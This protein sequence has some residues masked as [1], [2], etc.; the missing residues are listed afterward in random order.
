MFYINKITSDSTV[1]FAAEELKKYLR[2][3]IPEGGDV[4]ISYNPAAK[5]GFRLGLMQEFG[6]SVSDVEEAEL[7]DIIYIDCDEEG[8][9]IAGDNPR[10]V[11]LAVYEYLRQNGC[12][13]LF[14]GVDGEYIPMKDISPIKYR[15]A[16]S[17]RYRGMCN[18][19]AEYQS[20]MLEFIDF[21][22]KV[23]MN[24]FMM[25]FFIPVY[26]R[27]YYNH[28]ANEDARA[29]EP[30][31]DTQILQWK[32]QCEAELSKR[33]LQ[34]HDIGHGFTC[35]P[36]GIE[37]SWERGEGEVL[38]N[39]LTDEQRSF[40]AEING[41]R[42]LFRD[43]PG[44]TNFCMSN[45]VARNIVSDY[46]VEY[47]KNH[48]NVDYLH[49]WLADVQNN[50]CECEN[51]REKTPS[52]WYIILLNEIDKKLTDAGLD[53]RIVFISY[54][55]TTFAPL[56]ET[57]NNPRRFT[58]LIAP[59]FRSYAYSMPD[60]RGKT[61]IL[62]YKRNKNTFPPDLA[63]S[64]DYFDEWR[65]TWK[66][67]N[68]SYEYHFW[69]HQCYDLAGLMQARLI[70]DDVKLYK[71]NG[72][73]GIIEDGSQ[74]SFFPSG[75]SF[76]TYARTLF[77]SSLIYEE[78]EEDYLSHIYGEN[79]QK[80]RA[81]LTK[82]S[83]ALPFEFFSRDEA[84]KTEKVYD[85]PEMAGKISKI[86]EITKEGRALIAD[87]RPNDF[88]VQTLAFNLL[89]FHADFCDMISDWMVEK[90]QGNRE[91]AEELLN[92]AKF[93]IGKREAEFER[94]Y[95]QFIYFT[96]YYWIQNH[97]KSMDYGIALF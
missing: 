58:M 97:E 48:S 90:V 47:A 92:K 75:L 69:R 44:W 42:R 83:E 88:R 49:V 32:R 22:P 18:E 41:E 11:L 1:D 27:F 23:G 20:D 87:S 37:F 15:H 45:E 8:G 95:D 71:E 28:L 30:V 86:R 63:S 94:Y 21:L 29:A 66:G 89:S 46:V 62:P 7:D 81:Y 43:I 65:K 76:Y 38:D 73:N 60:G 80:I 57:L 12:R 53:T 77:D 14:P 19:G 67:S 56:E 13:W 6:I 82:I 10:S 93:E 54:V 2:M 96:E 35:D 51:C 70:N 79:W 55:D 68:L 3:M 4:K 74:R 25:E 5:D 61:E 24:V 39:R 26:Y 50:H 52:D 72:I 17:C 9:I 16:P 34:F 36:F 64:L 59:I 85:R 91:R 84:M 40:V 78:I 31:S 33:G